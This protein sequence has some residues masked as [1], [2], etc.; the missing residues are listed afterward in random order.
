MERSNYLKFG[1]WVVRKLP[2][3]LV[4]DLLKLFD[5]VGVERVDLL[6]RWREIFLD[7][8]RTSD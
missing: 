2:F 8:D 4:E 5:V 6:L 7:I 3:V 1:I